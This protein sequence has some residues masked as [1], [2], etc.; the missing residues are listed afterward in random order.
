MCGIFCYCCPKKKERTSASKLSKEFAKL[1]HRGP[2][3]TQE[4]WFDNVFLGFH[5]LSIMDTSEL[6]MQPFKYKDLICIANAEIYNYIDL[7]KELQIDFKTHCDCEVI[8]PLFDHIDRD[9]E[10]LCHKLDGEYAIII[11]DRTAKKLHICSDELRVRP[12]FVGT[13]SDGGIYISS[14]IKAISELCNKINAFPPASYS[15]FSTDIVPKDMEFI[16]HYDFNKK[17]IESSY[18]DAATKIRELLIASVEMKLHPDRE[19]AFLLSGGVDS[20]LVAS[21][22]AKLVYP[23]KIRTFTVGFSDNSP[24][25]LAAREVAKHIDSI[26]TEVI[27]EISDGIKEIEDVIYYNESYDETTVRASTPMKLAVKYIKEHHPDICVIYSGEVADE[28]FGSYLYFLNAPSAQEHR[29]ESIRLLE[30]LYLYDGLRA[31]RV[32]SSVS[33]ELRLP[34]FNR[35]FISYVLSIPPKY[36]NPRDNNMIEKKILRDAFDVNGSDGR[37]FL[38]KK[39]LWRTKNAMSDAVGYSWKDELKKHAQNSINKERYEHRD[40]LYSFNPPQT[41]EEFNYREIFAS[42]YSDAKIAKIIHDKWLP[43]WCGNVRDSSATMLNVFKET[44][45]D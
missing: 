27:A 45:F 30:E 20:S 18:G 32:V 15:T 10:K 37:A 23:A 7:E 41:P 19:Y 44:T 9:I 36:L 39:L 42:K 4:A 8:L 22:A 26:H 14:E 38:P 1:K 3:M 31:D 24:D 43:R 17:T 13:D 6:G 16:R 11:Y 12:I 5:R 33:C 25:I 28:L 2:D 29:N 34:F 40:K 35:E 21:I